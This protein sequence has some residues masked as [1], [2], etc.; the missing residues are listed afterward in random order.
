MAKKIIFGSELRKKSISVMEIIHKAVSSSLGPSGKLAL[1]ERDKQSSLITKDGVTIGHYCLPLED[2]AENL[3]AEKILETAKKTNAES[4][5]GTTTSIVLA[6]AL[7]DEAIKYIDKKQVDSVKIKDEIEK[8]LPKVLEE[9]DKFVIQIEDRKQM[10]D[11]ATIS[12]NNDEEIGKLIA[13][14]VEQVGEDGF[15]TL[16]QGNKPEPVLEIRDGIRLYHNSSAVF[17]KGEASRSFEDPNIITIAAGTR[18]E[19]PAV[20]GDLYTKKGNSG[21]PL[22]VI[23]SC[24]DQVIKA[25]VEW[26]KRDLCQCVHINLRQQKDQRDQIIRDISIATGSEIIDSATHNVTAAL[27]ASVLGKA[28]RVD[29]NRHTCSIIG[30]KGDEAKILLESEKIKAELEYTNS[31]YEKDLIK[32]RLARLTGT[33]A[34]ISVGGQTIDEAKERKDRFE[35]SLNATRSALQHGIIPGGGY[36][37]LLI[38]NYLKSDSIGGK[39]FKKAL[40]APVRQIISNTGV[41]AD[42]VI[43]EIKEKNMGYDAKRHEFVDLVKSGIV[44]PVQSVRSGLRNAVSIIDLLINLDTLSVNIIDKDNVKEVS[45]VLKE[46]Q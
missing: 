5:D 19:D 4:G 24:G 13:D 26:S 22:V 20:L 39:I 35:D 18:L 2:P 30:G 7:L 29:F 42:E 43:D 31:D 9:L 12:S 36:P 32:E 23:G 46:M 41:D 45:Q 40:S 27:P 37:L 25:L 16:T 11:I 1:L 15:V 21:K 10:Q 34:E 28:N 14:A 44:D 33:C 17:L 3:I 6:K 38:S 8:V